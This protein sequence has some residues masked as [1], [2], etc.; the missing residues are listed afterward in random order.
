MIHDMILAMKEFVP[1]YKSNHSEFEVIDKEITENH[2][3][4]KSPETEVYYS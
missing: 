4:I 3:I 2:H 1:E